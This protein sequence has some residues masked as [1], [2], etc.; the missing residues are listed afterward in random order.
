MKMQ[1]GNVLYVRID[2]KDGCAE[3]TEQDAVDCMEYL[4]RVAEERYLAAGLF[5]DME[6][7]TMDGAMLIFEAGDYKEASKIAEEDPIIAR[8]FYKYKLHK[9]NVM[10]VQ[11]GSEQQ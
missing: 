10:L 9:W 6:L 11:D 3:E 5:G 1:E 7:G 4:Q 2:Y 8:G